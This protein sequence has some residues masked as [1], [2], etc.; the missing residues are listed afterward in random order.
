MDHA[1]DNLGNTGHR[2]IEVHLQSDG[3]V[4]K[5]DPL[6]AEKAANFLDVLEPAKDGE[7]AAAVESNTAK[8]HGTL[9]KII[10]PV[11]KPKSS[12]EVIVVNVNP[13]GPVTI[14]TEPQGPSV[15][16]VTRLPDCH[17]NESKPPEDFEALF[18]DVLREQR[19]A[20]GAGVE[21]MGLDAESLPHD[22]WH[23]L[24]PAW[25]TLTDK[26][27]SILEILREKAREKSMNFD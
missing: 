16:V 21:H 3:P 23:Q 18:T 6:D 4:I 13:D 10:N 9:R 8:V 25:A 12:G 7:P 5:C 15:P 22:V 20:N 2:A 14:H 19:V 24:E 26:R 17:A 11:D 1:P 27:E